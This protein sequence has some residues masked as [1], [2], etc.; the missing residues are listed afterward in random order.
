MLLLCLMWVSVNVFNFLLVTIKIRLT[1]IR[2]LNIVYDLKMLS[3]F[4]LLNYLRSNI[5]TISINFISN[6]ITISINLVL[7]QP[8][9]QPL[10]V[11][12]SGYKWQHLTL[13]LTLV[14]TLVLLYLLSTSITLTNTITIITFNYFVCITTVF[15][16]IF[17]LYFRSP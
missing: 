1:F 15:I 7:Y 16:F 6:L 5:I 10:I 8:T 4:H 9:P 2:C 17:N 14:L 13:T 12:L 11:Y 3:L